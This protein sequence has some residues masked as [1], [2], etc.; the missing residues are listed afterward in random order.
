MIFDSL[1]IG[2]I[3]LEI[4]WSSMWIIKALHFRMDC[5]DNCHVLFAVNCIL[6]PLIR[7]AV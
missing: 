2:W 1:S 7:T 4:S 5:D 6:W 3:Y